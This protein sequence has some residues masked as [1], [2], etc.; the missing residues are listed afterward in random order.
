MKLSINILILMFFLIENQIKRTYIE[1][2]MFIRKLFKLFVFSLVIGCAV[3]HAGLDEGLVDIATP[4]IR[5]LPYG[6][7]A[8]KVRQSDQISSTNRVFSKE[9]RPKF[10]NCGEIVFDIYPTTSPK[11]LGEKVG[12]IILLL[13]PHSRRGCVE[14][15]LELT[16]LVGKSGS[17][18]FPTAEDF[19]VR[20]KGYGTAA[21]ETLF[22]ALRK[23]EKAGIHLP[24][25]TT[26]KLDVER[27]KPW[28]LDWYGRFGFTQEPD[29][30]WN[31]FF[32]MKCPVKKLKFPLHKKRVD[33]AIKIQRAWRSHRACQKS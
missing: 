16:I 22:A 5:N 33:A 17:H 31:E 19:A 32:V 26:I 23:G 6:G 8:L 7:V 18:H 27:H 4:R 25:D 15:T 11:M 1:G 10:G 29:N 30:L 24:K 12:D 20:K 14:P 21:L 3:T 9:G 13:F 28:L 2:M